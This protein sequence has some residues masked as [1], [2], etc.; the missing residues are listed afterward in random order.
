MSDV[1]KRTVERLEKF[2]EELEDGRHAWKF[3]KSEIERSALWMPL[4]TGPW[5]YNHRAEC[6]CEDCCGVRLHR[7]IKRFYKLNPLS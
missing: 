6:T 4:K 2:T 5:K 1:N 3:A 7:E